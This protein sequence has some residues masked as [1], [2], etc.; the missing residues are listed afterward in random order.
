MRPNVAI[1]VSYLYEEYK[2]DDFSLDTDTINSLAPKNA[3]NN[4][5]ASTI[6]AGY[7][8]RPYTAHTWWLRAKYLW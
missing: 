4:T 8:F 1:G 6:Y 2:V 7:L 3:S 5:F